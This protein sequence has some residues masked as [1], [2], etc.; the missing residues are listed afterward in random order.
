MTLYWKKLNRTIVQIIAYNW[1]CGKFIWEYNIG[2]NHIEF[3]WMPW[4][5]DRSIETYCATQNMSN[6]LVYLSLVTCRFFLSRKFNPQY[7]IYRES[8]KILESMFFKWL[9]LLI[10]YLSR[11]LDF[12]ILIRMETRCIGA[13]AF[14]LSD[15]VCSNINKCYLPLNELNEEKKLPSLS[16]WRFLSAFY[17]ILDKRVGAIW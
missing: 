13:E 7:A 5:F 16:S 10:K 14:T 1:N 4:Q 2:V 9:S 6:N 3:I 12:F 17:C 11:C 8:S 15:I